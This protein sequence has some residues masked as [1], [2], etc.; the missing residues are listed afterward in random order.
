[1]SPPRIHHRYNSHRNLPL[2]FI[3]AVHFS[4]SG[5]FLFFGFFPLLFACACVDGDSLARHGAL[6]STDRK[7]SISAPALREGG[8][9]SE[10]VR[11]EGFEVFEY[12]LL[13]I[14]SK[15]FVCP[16]LYYL[17]KLATRQYFL[18]GFAYT[19]FLFLRGRKIYTLVKLY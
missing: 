5:F 2:R 18:V 3:A 10:V 17:G 1:M 4:W 9:L 12:L 19:W 11:K 16:H 6:G 8:F 15:R 7:A 14:L 13:S